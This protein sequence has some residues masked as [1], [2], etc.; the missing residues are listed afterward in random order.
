MAKEI[1]PGITVDPQVV[2]GRPVVAGT[3][4][5][6]EAVLGELRW[7]F[8][9]RGGSRRLPSDGRADSG[10]VRLCHPDAEFYNCLCHQLV[11]RHDGVSLWTRTS[12][13]G[14]S[15]ISGLRAMTPSMHT[16]LGSA[17]GPTLMSLPTPVQREPH[18]SLRI[19]ISNV[20]QGSF[21][22]RMPASS[23]SNCHRPGQEKTKCSVSWRR[24]AAWQ[25]NRSRIRWSSSSHRKSGSSLA[26]PASNSVRGRAARHAGCGRRA[27][28]WSSRRAAR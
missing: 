1:F 26:L 18:L 4:V 24:Y 3:R 21:R 14:S 23:L 7:R 6:V 25:T 5:P 16:R 9:L 2:H 13:H 17:H 8:Q 11:V 22:R 28:V 12:L 27:L 10:R 19:T 20:I 15:S